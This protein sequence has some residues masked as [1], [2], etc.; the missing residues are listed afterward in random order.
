M[1]VQKTVKIPDKKLLGSLTQLC[2]AEFVAAFFRAEMPVVTLSN[3]VVIA[4]HAK[5]RE[6]RREP[7]LDSTEIVG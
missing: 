5:M 6:N 3:L 7:I 4:H 2:R 1:G